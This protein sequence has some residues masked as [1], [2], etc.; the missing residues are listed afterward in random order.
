MKAGKLKGVKRVIVDPSDWS[1]VSLVTQICS[2]SAVE[3]IEK[4]RNSERVHLEGQ[5]LRQTLKLRD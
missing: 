1:L 5:G 4:E 2:F 3:T